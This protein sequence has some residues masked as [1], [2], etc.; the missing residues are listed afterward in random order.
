MEN[1]LF[2]REMRAI[3][4]GHIYCSTFSS[5]NDPM[6]GFFRSTT[7]MRRHT[8]YDEVVN[9][10]KNEKQQLGIAS[11]TEGYSNELMW[12]HYANGF[13]GICIGYATKDLLAGLSDDYALARIQYLDKP[14]RLALPTMSMNQRARAVLCTKNLKWMYEREWRLFAPHSGPAT[15]TNDA[16][17]V[18]ILGPRMHPEDREEIVERLSYST[19]MQIRFAAV[20]GYDVKVYDSWEEIEA[21]ISEIL[22]AFI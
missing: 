19:T 16:A 1:R 3:E 7:G 10:I 21:P 18:I 13:S 22:D 5:M 11:L 6:E 17:R 8:A 12:A 9:E 14:Y 15:Y 4:E 20:D 2:E